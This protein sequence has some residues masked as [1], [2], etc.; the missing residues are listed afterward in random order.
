MASSIAGS[1][2]DGRRKDL[3]DI[4]QAKTG[5]TNAFA[6]LVHRHTPRAYAIA[7]A[8]LHSHADAEDAVQEAWLRVWKAIDRF[9]DSCAFTPWLSS[10]VGNA[11]RDLGRRRVI[12]QMESLSPNMTRPGQDTLT[13][14]ARTEA[15]AAALRRLT[16]RRRRIVVLHDVHGLLHKEIAAILDIPSGTVRAELSYARRDLRISLTDWKVAV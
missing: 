3:E 5:D 12:R 14:Y 4:R 11:A 7:R 2:A 10:I 16:P 9:D 13:A 1:I 6:A 8:C 15:V